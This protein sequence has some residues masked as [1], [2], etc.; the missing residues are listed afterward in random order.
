MMEALVIL[1]CLLLLAGLFVAIRYEPYAKRDPHASDAIITETPVV[2]KIDPK[3]M[4]TANPKGEVRTGGRRTVVR[5]R[6]GALVEPL[7]RG[8]LRGIKADARKLWRD[9][10]QD[11]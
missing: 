10:G 5:T 1:I 11:R 9:D 7:H 6:H 8:I 4:S 3:A 2:T